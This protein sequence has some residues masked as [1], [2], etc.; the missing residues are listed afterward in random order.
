MFH[1][2]AKAWPNPIFHTEVRGK[3]IEWMR[4]HPQDFVNFL[5]FR[6]GKQLTLDTYLHEMAQDG[7]YGDN[8]TLQA[9]CKAFSVTVMVLKDENHQFSW[10]GVNDHPPQ[11]RVF[12]FYLHRYHYE[13]LLLPRFVVL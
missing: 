5:P 13:N 1:A 4:S 2:F 6:H 3:A 7:C 10:M 12:W 11:R 8:L 9:V